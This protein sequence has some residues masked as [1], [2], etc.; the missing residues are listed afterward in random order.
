MKQ[1]TKNLKTLIL[2]TAAALGLAATAFA[3]DPLKAP[4]NPG[5]PVQQSLL[6]STY[7]GVAWN[8]Y[9]L[10]DGPPSVAR[11]V[12]A[13]FNQRLGDNLDLGVDY[14]WLRAR[15]SDYSASHQ[16][17]GL[18][19]ASFSKQSWGKPYASTGLNYAWRHGSVSGRRGSLGLGAETGVE[20]QAASAWTIAPFVGWDRQTGFNQND[21]RYG[22]RTTVFFTNRWSATATAQ[23]MDYKRLVDRIG[24]SVGL[25]YHF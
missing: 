8:Y 17:L 3:Q 21:L 11:G 6:G 18:S 24:Y 10:D 2:A 13:Y 19:V 9:K 14:E 1:N 12:S 15:A 4:A 23:K 22:A 5:D 25:N 7:S 16:Q 20:F